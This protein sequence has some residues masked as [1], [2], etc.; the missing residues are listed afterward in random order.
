MLTELHVHQFALIDEVTLELQHGMTVF[1]GETGAGKSI[2]IDAL[3]ALFGSRTRTDWVRYGSNRAE[4]SGTIIC[5][6]PRLHSLLE[7]QEIESDDGEVLLRRTISHD[8]RSSAWVNGVRVAA[9]VLQQVGDICLD[10]HGQH[11]HQALLRP[12]FQRQLLDSALP[13]PLLHTVKNTHR[14]WQQ[15]HKQLQ[16][17]REGF[18]EAKENIVWLKDEQERLAGLGLTINLSLSLQQ[19]VEQGRYST[20]IREAAANALVLLDHADPNVR[21]LLAEASRNLLPAVELSPE[22]RST[23]EVFTQV[24]TLLGDIVPTLQAV[25]DQVSDAEEIEQNER[26]LSELNDAMR[27]HQRDES[28][29]IQLLTE[30]EE[31]L[32]HYD[33]SAWDEEAQVL[34]LEKKKKTYQ[35]AAKALHQAR[36]KSGEALCRDLRPYL[37]ELALQGMQIEARVDAFAN[38]E[39]HWSR[40]GWDHIAIYASSNP[41][42]PFRPLAEIASGGEMSRFVLALKACDAMKHAPFLAIFDEID[43]GIGGEIAWHVG[44]LLRA[45]GRDRQ[46]LAISHLPQVAACA[47]QQ[48]HITKMQQ[49][50]RTTTT[51]QTV[52]E[53]ER[54]DEIARMLGGANA[55]SRKHAQNMLDMAAKR[56]TT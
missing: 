11:E 12:Q 38:D 49:G 21:T 3:G 55:E 5:A 20:L 39:S 52:S 22:L 41:G 42:E 46:V 23:H 40:D 27:R 25:Q 18:E 29:L 43:S 53:V 24:D 44:T 26:Q 36:V 51:I 34:E 48:I 15:A 31:K 32:M 50:E 14:Q 8:G 16:N 2:L 33:T 56:Q 1:S 6:N 30:I 17:I 10:L 4:V 35:K 19:K 47:D 9:K 28:G 54:I 37:D 13:E 45:M 7:E